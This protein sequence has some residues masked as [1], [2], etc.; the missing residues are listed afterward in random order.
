M[1][2]S[3]SKCSVTS[4]RYGMARPDTPH[5]LVSFFYLRSKGVSITFADW[6]WGQCRSGH[7]AWRARGESVRDDPSPPHRFQ[8]PAHSTRL[9][10]SN[11]TFRML[12]EDPFPFV[13]TGAFFIPTSW[14][15]PSP[16]TSVITTDPIFPIKCPFFVA[17]FS[18]ALQLPSVYSI[19]SPLCCCNVLRT[20]VFRITEALLGVF[21][22]ECVPHATSQTKF[23][24]RILIEY[25]GQRFASTTLANSNFFI[26]PCNVFKLI[27]LR[28][29][30]YH[31][32]FC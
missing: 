5:D 4:D 31:C 8:R 1:Q 11:E 23:L 13:M 14:I 20:K 26:C 6:V 3:T 25:F 27:R 2:S 24:L 18:L 28:D 32:R 12:L 22:S 9:L 16:E 17:P 21:R 29:I 10:T 30:C 15:F 7:S 19:I